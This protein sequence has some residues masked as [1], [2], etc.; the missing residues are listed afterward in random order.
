[1]TSAVNTLKKPLALTAA[2]LGLAGLLV[3]CGGNGQD[4]VAGS[5]V[6][7]NASLRVGDLIPFML[8]VQQQK[9]SDMGE[10]LVLGNATLASDETSEPTALP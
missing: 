4:Y 6:P 10:P 1:M 7:T 5:D 3:A 8:A 9:T 2:A